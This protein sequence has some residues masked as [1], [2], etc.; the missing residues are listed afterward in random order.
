MRGNARDILILYRITYFSTTGS[1]GLK[2]SNNGRTIYN[3]YTII[4]ISKTKKHITLIK[5]K[6][7]IYA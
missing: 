7:N 4:S 2:R 1:A 6:V 3:I 5:N